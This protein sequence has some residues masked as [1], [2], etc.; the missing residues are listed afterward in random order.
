MSTSKPFK[1]SAQLVGHTGDVRALAVS[2][3]AA[4]LSASRDGTARVWIPQPQAKGATYKSEAC[5]SL[6]PHTGYVN[7]AA[8]WRTSD[9]CELALLSDSVQT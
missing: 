5:I 6:E 2:P 1:L 4:L 3:D 9:G 7:S 8:W